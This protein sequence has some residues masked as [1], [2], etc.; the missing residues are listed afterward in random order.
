MEP[1]GKVEVN[2]FMFYVEQWK[3]RSS[4]KGGKETKCQVGLQLLVLSQPGVS[5]LLWLS[6]LGRRLQKRVFHC[7]D[8]LVTG[9]RMQCKVDPQTPSMPNL[10]RVKANKWLS[11]FSSR[12]ETCGNFDTK[13][14][15]TWCF[16]LWECSGVLFVKHIFRK[17]F[18]LFQSISLYFQ[19]LS[20]II[21]KA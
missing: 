17:G 18:N 4:W 9:R 8:I 15:W 19:T 3:C 6:V 20:P 14:G 12:Q 5:S 21:P 13:G 16:K 7:P 1:E 11:I 2:L 10:G